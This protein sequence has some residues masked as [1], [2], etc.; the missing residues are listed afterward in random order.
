MD[1]TALETVSVRFDTIRTILYERSDPRRSADSL[2]APSDLSIPLAISSPKP[3]KR[4]AR[5]PALSAV[6]QPFPILSFRVRFLVSLCF[7]SRCIASH[8][9]ALC[10]TTQARARRTI[11][12]CTQYCTIQS[13]RITSNV[14]DL[15]RRRAPKALR[16]TEQ[17]STVAARVYRADETTGDHSILNELNRTE[18]NRMANG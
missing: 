14:S 10:S 18:P 15:N 12:Y 5:P 17:Y 2:C 4:P 8:C 13:R 6:R 9:I 3:Q 16:R 1:C 11:L 7:A